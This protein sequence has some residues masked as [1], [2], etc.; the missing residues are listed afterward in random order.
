M[1]LK[2]R[3]LLVLVVGT[4]LGLTISLG[5][6]VLA[7]RQVAGS[8]EPLPLDEARLLAEVLE[9]VRRDYVEV[10]DNHQLIE[11]AIRGMI[12]DLDPHSQF[13]NPREYE[14][15]RISTTGNYSGVGLD[16]SLDGGVVTVVAPI[17]DS[18]AERAG[19]MP[20]DVVISIDDMPV[21]NS[22]LNATIGLMRGEPGTPV[23]LDVLRDGDDNPLHFALVRSQIQVNSVRSQLLDRDFGYL[24]LTHFSETTARDLYRAITRLKREATGPLRGLVL[25]MR[26]NPGGVLDAAVDVADAF[27]DR[28]LVVTGNGRVRD[29]RFERYARP[30]DVIDGAALVA[31]VNAGSASASEIVAGALRDND[32]ALVV[33]TRTY[34]KGSVQTVMPLSDGRAIKLTTSRYYTPSGESIHERGIEPDVAIAMTPGTTRM[35]RGPGSVVSIADD[36]QLQEALRVVGYRP[37]MQSKAQ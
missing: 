30:G 9:R 8:N 21:Q 11:S 1:S 20:G 14:E 35:F 15:I 34:G 33:G 23:G 6:G 25:D 16:V 5:G 22:D 37:I 17:D 3:S 27:L 7:E 26:N 18:P 10:V 29:A 2:V 4:V 24:K 13:L 12:A 31:L 19:I 28:G 32:R 36:I